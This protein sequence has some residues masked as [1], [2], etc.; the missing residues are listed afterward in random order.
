[1]RDTLR[2]LIREM[3]ST[4]EPGKGTRAGQLSRIIRL[5]DQLIPLYLELE[6]LNRTAA[7]MPWGP[8]RDK[9]VRQIPELEEMI[10]PLQAELERQEAKLG[11]EY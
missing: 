5:Q 10:K 1:M 7:G 4:W 3:A 8:E 11:T 2:D 6:R 9:I